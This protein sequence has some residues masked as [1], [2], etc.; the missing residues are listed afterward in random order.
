MLGC[1]IEL[2][3]DESKTVIEYQP[4]PLSRGKTS[5]KAPQI[6]LNIVGLFLTL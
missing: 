4:S 5:M 1:K 3:P 6:F 2:G